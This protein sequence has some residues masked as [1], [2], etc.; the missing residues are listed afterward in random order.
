MARF[1]LLDDIKA[2]DLY[3]RTK[4]DPKARAILEEGRKERRQSKNDI[5]PGQLVMFNYFN[6]KTVED[7]EYYDA[8]PCTIFFGV[9]HTEE[10]KRVIG[11]NIHYFPPRA[12]YMIMD[13]IYDLYRP[14]YTKYFTSGL[15][16]DLDAFDYH[17]LIEELNKYDLS[18]AVRMYIPARIG[19]VMV[20]PPK[21]WSTAIFTEGWFHKQTRMTI[22]RYWRERM[23]GYTGHRR[24][25]K[26]AGDKKEDK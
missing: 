18:W 19:E 22:M 6:P 14:V 16:H 7:L 4:R 21:L 17:Y 23:A 8:K 15:S 13:R 20:I 9:A 11:F 24:K 3:K 10:G 12:R 26:A 2:N 5:F 25:R 1:R